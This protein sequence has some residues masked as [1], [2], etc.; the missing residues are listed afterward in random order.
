MRA[1][2]RDPE[3][4][5]RPVRSPGAGPLLEPGDHGA[6]GI[7]PELSDIGSRAQ[8]AAIVESILQPS[9]TII[10]PGL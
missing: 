1:D 8:L 6:G 3:R 10:E 7:G 9:A 5:G 2:T 4:Q